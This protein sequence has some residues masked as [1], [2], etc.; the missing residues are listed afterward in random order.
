MKKLF[1]PV[2]L[3]LMVFPGCKGLEKEIIIS[4]STIQK[5]VEKKFPIEKSS[6]VANIKLS[7]PSVFFQGNCIGLTM[8]YSAFLL[9]S[10]VGGNVSFQCRPVYKPENATFYMSDFVLTDITMNSVNSFI[11]KD[12]LMGI[13][14]GIVNSYFKDYPLYRLNPDDYK[15]N[16]AK[17]MLKDVSVRGDNLILLLSF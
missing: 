13:I 3:L 1:I 16:L 11:G 6:L 5:M 10:E 7:S 15:Q 14:S 8:Q 2:L 12:K 9:I 4:K 17:T